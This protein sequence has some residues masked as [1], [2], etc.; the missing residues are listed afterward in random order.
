LTEDTTSSFSLPTM[1]IT[2]TETMET[3]LTTH[4]VET[5][6]RILG[7]PR[8]LRNK[9]HVMEDYSGA[10]HFDGWISMRDAVKI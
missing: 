6:E 5:E 7:K 9:R 1:A 3:T 10:P 2:K 4:T 8:R